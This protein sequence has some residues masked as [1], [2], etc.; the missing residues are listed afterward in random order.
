MV[1][2]CLCVREREKHR[3]L[4][5]EGERD[6]EIERWKEMKRLALVIWAMQDIFIDDVNYSVSLFII[7]LFP[8]EFALTF[9]AF[10]V[11]FIVN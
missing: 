10:S 2:V 6:T 9:D 4:E 3:E 11:F 5:R 1:G 8:F 7:I